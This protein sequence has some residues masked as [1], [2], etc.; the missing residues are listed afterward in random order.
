MGRVRL[1]VVS[2]AAYVLLY[3]AFAASGGVADEGAPRVA[4]IGAGVGGA[5]AT[6]LLLEQHPTVEV[7][8]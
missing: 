3:A 5:A 8:V 4:V 6:H 7:S 2:L 1:Y